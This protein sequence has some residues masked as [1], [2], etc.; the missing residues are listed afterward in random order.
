MSTDTVKNPINDT[1]LGLSR[2]VTYNASEL[3]ER[4][5][6]DWKE[7]KQIIKKLYPRKVGVNQ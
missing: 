6:N 7:S 5:K 4:R 2:L 1:S 3:E